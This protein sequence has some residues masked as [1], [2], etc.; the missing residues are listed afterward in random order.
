MQC[1]AAAPCRPTSLKLRCPICPSATV[2][3]QIRPFNLPD[4]KPMRDLNPNDIETLISIKGMVTRTSNVI[5]E[6]VRAHFVCQVRPSQLL[7]RLPL[8]KGF[9]LCC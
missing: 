8:K 9:W 6:M 7:P 4:S 1:T 5:P 3:P 2:S